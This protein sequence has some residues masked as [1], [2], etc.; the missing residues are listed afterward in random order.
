MEG[1]LRKSLPNSLLS[2]T[3]SWQGAQ[4]GCLYDRISVVVV[5]FKC[6][7]SAAESDAQSQQVVGADIVLVDGLS[8]RHGPRQGGRRAAEDDH[9][10]IAG[11]LDFGPP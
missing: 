1:E 11:A 3:R 2:K 8:H 7:L 10:P 4:P 9:D 6:R 5:G